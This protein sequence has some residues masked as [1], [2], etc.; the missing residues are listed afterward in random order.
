[1]Q[2]EYCK[3]IF[4]IVYANLICARWRLTYWQYISNVPRRE[5]WSQFGG[6][7]NVYIYVMLLWVS[8]I[9]QS[10]TWSPSGI[11]RNASQIKPNCQVTKIDLKMRKLYIYQR[12]MVLLEVV[13]DKTKF[14][15]LYFASFTEYLNLFFLDIKVFIH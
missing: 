8:S 3:E 4:N 10:C 6:F 1:M 14:K 12:R 5:Y 15:F 13:M 7:G 11:S 9:P 2:R